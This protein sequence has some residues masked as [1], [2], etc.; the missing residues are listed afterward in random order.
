[1]LG[2]RP[3]KPARGPAPKAEALHLRRL[4]RNL[5]AALCEE[6]SS[7]NRN[8]E[9]DGIE[10]EERAA[11]GRRL[12]PEAVTEQKAGYQTADALWTKVTH[13][14]FDMESANAVR[15]DHPLTSLDRTRSGS[16]RNTG[17]SKDSRAVAAPFLTPH[18]IVQI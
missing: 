9:G 12:R 11:A 10:A 14:S 17:Y 2:S 6:I 13:P 8:P 1:L 5:F 7:G 18:P 3:A 15:C 16:T 4:W